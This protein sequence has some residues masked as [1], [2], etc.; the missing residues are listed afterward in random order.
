MA[1]RIAVIA[2]GP[3][4]SMRAVLPR[5]DRHGVADRLLA[6]AMPGRVGPQ[7]VAKVVVDGLQGR[8]VL[9]HQF[10][11]ERGHLG[12]LGKGLE[13][14]VEV[15]PPLLV[16]HDLARL[17]VRN[18]QVQVLPTA[19]YVLQPIGELREVERRMLAIEVVGERHID[20]RIGL[21]VEVDLHVALLGQGR[22]D[23]PDAARA[24]HLGEHLL[25]AF[26]ADDPAAVAIGVPVDVLAALL[27]ELARP[28]VARPLL[29]RIARRRQHG[30]PIQAIEPMNKIGVGKQFLGVGCGGRCR[31]KGR[32][33]N[34]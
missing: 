18:R 24:F 23:P 13:D 20:D 27:V 8:G 31:K 22:P 25:I 34:D 15:R 29:A 28:V 9:L 5:L 6:L 10:R 14:E 2:L 3:L 30:E 32:N 1:P 33:G 12:S 11:T 19:A 17:L 21:A 26:A 4:S 7:P 16:G